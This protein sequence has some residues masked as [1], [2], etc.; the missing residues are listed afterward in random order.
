M[1]LW[2]KLPLAHL[3]DGT[4][5]L[6]LG[7]SHKGTFLLMFLLFSYLISHSVCV[8]VCVCV[9]PHPPVLHNDDWC[10]DQWQEWM[11]SGTLFVATLHCPRGV[12]LFIFP[13]FR[14]SESSKSHHFSKIASGSTMLP[15]SLP[16]SP[17]QGKWHNNND[18]KYFKKRLWNRKCKHTLK[19]E[20]L[21]KDV[22]ELVYRSIHKQ[23][24]RS[25]ARC[26]KIH[27]FY[28]PT[29]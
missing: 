20:I 8:C 9:L 6:A 23:Q 12:C 7:L 29:I 11:E 15:L 24:N 5:I 18:C 21:H 26:L 16:Q 25:F 10:L 19:I 3:D 28:F 2:D 4:A 13:L 27:A 14:T 17:M 1:G 22:R